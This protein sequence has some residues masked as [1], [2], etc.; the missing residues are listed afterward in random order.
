MGRFGVIGK[1][2]KQFY[3][4]SHFFSRISAKAD[5]ADQMCG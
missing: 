1:T 2:P 4:S 3:W 5:F